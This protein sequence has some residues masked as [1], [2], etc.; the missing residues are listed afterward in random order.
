LNKLFHFTS[1]ILYEYYAVFPSRYYIPNHW[2]KSF[3]LLDKF[4]FSNLKKICKSKIPLWTDVVVILK[5]VNYGSKKASV[6]GNK[7]NELKLIYHVILE[8]L[9]VASNDLN[10]TIIMLLLTMT[11]ICQP[12]HIQKAILQNNLFIRLNPR[13]LQNSPVFTTEWS[14]S[15][16]PV[17]Y[18]LMLFVF[19]R[20]KSHWLFDCL[21]VWT[22]SVDLVQL[23]F[24][25]IFSKFNL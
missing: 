4:H 8:I 6:E 17:V 11:K 16:C 2:K 7:L 5:V 12:K 22:L 19:V 9:K 15:P 10:E 24:Q 25:Q 13:F 1:S 3:R 18:P 20:R 21:L 23:C 14:V